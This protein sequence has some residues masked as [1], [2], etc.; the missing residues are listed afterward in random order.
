[1]NDGSTAV[2]WTKDWLR[3]CSMLVAAALMTLSLGCGPEPPVD[4][5][6]T[7]VSGV[8]TLDGKPLPGG[9]LTF[10]AVDS[11]IGSTVFIG[12]GGRYKTTRA[13]IGA[14]VVTI[15]TEMLKYGNPTAYVPIPAKYADPTQSGLTAEIKPGENE[16][17]D[18]ALE[19]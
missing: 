15:E 16:N 9:A 5:N 3:A 19:D 17:V 2:R 7:T 6:R 18:F 10:T 12:E 4:E 13:P 1:M 8:V 11:V 14:N